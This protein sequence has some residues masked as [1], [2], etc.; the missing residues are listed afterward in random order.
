MLTTFCLLLT[1]TLVHP[2]HS[3]STEMQWNE[4]TKCV[5]LSMRIDLL[6]ERWLK[7][8]AARRSK[9]AKTDVSD[10]AVPWELQCLRRHLWFDPVAS[11][12]GSAVRS[13][14][15]GKPIRWVGQQQEGAYVWWFFEVFCE[16][17]TPPSRLRTNLLFERDRS[18]QH[19]YVVLSEDIDESKRAFDL[20]ERQP[21]SAI[22]W[23][24]P[25]T[26]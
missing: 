22:T 8:Q 24:N 7:K 17:G 13:G 26:R 14:F 16:D 18:F 4:T 10:E 25:S 2:F 19:R 20:V 11:K 5:E 6:D 12:K 3:T 1:T 9:A 15:V 23:S 21:E